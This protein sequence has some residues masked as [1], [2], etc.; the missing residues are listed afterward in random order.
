MIIRLRRTQ[1]NMLL[2]EAREKYPVEA[3]G[4]LFG[5]IKSDEILVE[6]IVPLKNILNSEVMFQV[7][8]EEFLKTLIE[9]EEI[10]LQHIGFFHSHPGSPNPSLIDLKYM[11]LWPESIWII[12]SCTNFMVAAYQFS[13]GELKEVDIIVESE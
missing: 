8:S 1:I 12:I 7:N 9:H 5:L 10:G 6:K 11:E 4:V 13:N 3:C 2:K